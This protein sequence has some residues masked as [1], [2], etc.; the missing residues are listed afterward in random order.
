[1]IMN[2]NLNVIF[3]KKFSMLLNEN[4]LLH[5]FI[6]TLSQ[7]SSNLFC[8]SQCLAFYRRYTGALFCPD[9]CEGCLTFR[10]GGVSVYKERINIFFFNFTKIKNIGESNYENS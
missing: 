10:R 1:M 5:I 7:S 4:Y 8:H 9:K 3:W 6:A 2:L